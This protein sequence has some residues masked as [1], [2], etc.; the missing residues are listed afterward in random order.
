MTRRVTLFALL[1]GASAAH[2]PAQSVG[3]SRAAV[4]LTLP[5]GARALALGEAWGAVA[6]DESAL[7]YNPAQLA[8]VRAASAGGS[9]QRYIAS[10]TLG[11]FAAATPLGRGTIAIGAQILDYGSEEE[12]VAASGSLGQQGEPTGGRVSA[13]DLALTAGYGASL[14]AA[15]AWRLGGAVKLA[16]QRVADASGSAVAA[17]LGVAYAA[18]RGW[19]V[20]AALQHLG[21]RLTLASV[22]APLPWTWRAAAASPVVRRERATFRAMAEARRS[23]GG[24]ATGVLAAEG[25]WRTS[26]AGPMLAGRAA[27]A[28]RGSG[29]D[30]SPLT[31]GGGVTL[32]RIA[33]DYAWEGFDLLG[34]ATH[35]VGVR[36]AALPRGQ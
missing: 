14:G 8:L 4:F 2:S 17:D 5:A 7:F 23:S 33:V 3:E 28:L 25:T 27:Y 13:Q 32:G 6:D 21:S 34:G 24:L 20:A 36:F 12:I 9:L 22:R 26:P 15:R 10:T 19:V 18:A 30:K 35:R 11:A 31:L 1:L 29:N 16:R